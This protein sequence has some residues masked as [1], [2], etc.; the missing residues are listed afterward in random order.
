LELLR[1]LLEKIA[2][3]GQVDTRDVSQLASRDP[4]IKLKVN[5]VDDLLY[6]LKDMLFLMVCRVRRSTHG[7]ILTAFER[8]QQ[9]QATDAWILGPRT[10]L[11]L[12][13]LLLQ[14]GMPEENLPQR[15]VF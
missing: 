5:Q 4:K 8:F 15:L 7:V 11:E 6:K 2:E 13:A 1:K 12:P 9:D 10:Y 3:D 14:H